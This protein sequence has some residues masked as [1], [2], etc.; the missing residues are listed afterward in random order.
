MT[1]GLNITLEVLA[2]TK[3][4]VA[5]KVLIP[6][7]DSEH[8]A[9]QEGALR[10]LSKRRSF[11]GQTALLSRWHAMDEPWQAI[12]AERPNRMA[13]ALRAAVLGDDAR[14]CA[15]A[16][17]AILR[18]HEYDLL[19]V[20][21]GAA[22]DETNPHTDRAARTVL[23]LCGLLCEELA[24]PRDYTILR[25][26][27]L[28]RQHVISSL[29]RS[30]ERFSK[31]E[32]KECLEAFLS[33]ANRDNAK[34]KRVLQNPYDDCFLPIVDMFKNS[35]RVGAMRLLLSY[36]DDPRA[37]MSA[38]GALIYRNDARFLDC[39]MKK[40]GFEPSSSAR[41]NLKRVKSIRWVRENIDVL[42]SLDDAGQHSAVQ[43]VMA[44]GMNRLEVY[45]MISYL[46]EYGK[47]GGRRAASAALA[48]FKGAEANDLVLRR[49]DDS[50][51]KV[52]ANLL[53]QLRERSIPGAF[54]KL[55]EM[56]ESRHEIVRSAVRSC[57]DEFSFKRY[58]AAFDMLDDEVRKSTGQ[59][60]RRIDPT[61]CRS[62]AQEMQEPARGKRLRALA[63]ASALKVVD[64]LEAYI[65]EL[66]ADEDHMVR[67]EAARTLAAC[68]T[69]QS[70]LALREAMSDSSVT[71]RE[72]AQLSLRQLAAVL[73]GASGTAGRAGPSFPPL[74]Q[75]SDQGGSQ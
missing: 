29:E 19:P 12:L 58:L 36:L 6:A 14:M 44:S 39:L 70:R 66:L 72:T 24:A 61:A 3:N 25:D 55:L 71:V 33:L 56:A 51:P 1:E 45:P 74:S 11:Q 59:L 48:E 38:I 35:R 9:I 26:P 40:I 53:V 46:T 65:I 7:L 54:S 37:P 13:G 73:S 8:A 57:L 60:V 67:T 22:E 30:V 68:N 18:F 64:Q 2:N 69:P 5:V 41:K 31:H 27:Q 47:P 52:Q 62:L 63:V 10:A 15:N 50:D 32:R 23:D 21:I 34:L 17:D 42:D 43:M 49:L 16:C 20:L 4:E 75:P 28:V